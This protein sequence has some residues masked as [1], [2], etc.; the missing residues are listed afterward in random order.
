[1][2][3]LFFKVQK[4]MFYRESFAELSGDPFPLYIMIIIYRAVEVSRASCTLECVSLRVC[5]VRGTSKTQGL[6][7]SL[8]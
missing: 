8:T 7:N 6:F 1:M 5:C 2:D 3:I 4:V